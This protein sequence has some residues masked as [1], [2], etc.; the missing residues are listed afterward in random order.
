MRVFETPR[1]PGKLGKSYSPLRISNGSQVMINAVKMAENSDELIV[2]V[3]ELQGKPADDVTIFFGGPVVSAREVNGQEEEL[4]TAVSTQDKLTFS[5]APYQPKAFAVRLGKPRTT[6][7]RPLVSTPVAL[8]YDLDGISLDDGRADGNIDGEGNSLAGELLPA[9]LV[10][11]GVRFSFGPKSAGAMNVV[12]CSGQQIALPEGDWKRVYMLMLATGGPVLEASKAMGPNGVA[13]TAISLQDYTE[14]IGQ[15]NN[16]MVNGRMVADA[17]EILPAYINQT[18]VAWAGTHRHTADGRNDAYKFT[19]LYAIP[20][21][22]NPGARQLTLP[23]NPRLK[24]LAVSVAGDSRDRIHPSTALYDEAN[25]KFARIAADRISFIDS[26]I[27]HLSTPFPGVGL[28]YTLD[29]TEPT[30]GSPLFEKAF[31]VSRTATI[32]AAPFRAGH[33]TGPATRMTVRKLIPR[34]AVDAGETKPGLRCLY[35]EGEWRRLP[36]FASIKLANEIVVERV[37]IPS[38]ARTEH[39]GLVFKGYI[40]LSED[41]LYEFAVSSD[42]GSALIVGDS[43]LCDN[44]GVH[45]DSEVAGTIALKA[46]MHPIEVRM[47]QRTGGQAL[48]LRIAGPGMPKRE[49]GASMLF[50]TPAAKV[51]KR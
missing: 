14:P 3:R 10:Y 49:V 47:F 17:S 51:R 23:D 26:T 4:G 35:Y 12:A 5:L 45:G 7:V 29:G 19:Y 44:D 36:D 48:N 41:G 15:W 21:E 16:R 27:V 30:G 37:A 33:Q 1:H 18:P 46:G 43:L 6:M 9:E 42:D 32:K 31:P 39:Y 20:V 22:L 8:P 11:D 13:A 2:R 50:H 25:E 38:I 34:V 28:R 40:R 24:L